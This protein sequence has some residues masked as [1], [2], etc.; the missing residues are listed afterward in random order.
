[1]SHYSSNLE[2]E[3]PFENE[4][5]L[6]A[7]PSEGKIDLVNVNVSLVNFNIVNLMFI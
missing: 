2:H 5:S 6:P 3:G 4:R 1:M 7:W